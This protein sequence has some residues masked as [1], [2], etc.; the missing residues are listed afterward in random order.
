MALQRKCSCCRRP[1]HTKQ[2]CPRL[3]AGDMRNTRGKTVLVNVAKLHVKSPHTVD[4]SG[5]MEKPKWHGVDVFQEAPRD[6]ESRQVIDWA[7]M[8]REANKSQKSV[9]FESPKVHK[10]RKSIKS[11]IEKNIQYLI[12]NIKNGTRSSLIALHQSFSNALN[13]ILNLKLF[14]YRRL[15]YAS[16]AIF[17]LIAIPF[18]AVGYYQKLKSD[19]AQVVGESTNAFLTLQSSTIAALQ[20]NLGQ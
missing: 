12:S 8:V 6:R 3:S 19:G 13:A 10:V 15:A 18:P 16:V 20:A 4:L 17:L 2:K 1:G 9:E 14:N 11:E 7:E 5:K